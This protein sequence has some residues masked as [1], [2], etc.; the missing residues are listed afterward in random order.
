MS[1][2]FEV[3][4]NSATYG[5]DYSM[6]STDVVLAPGETSKRVPV[7]IIDDQMPELEESF[8]VS[9]LQQITGGATLGAVRECT[10]V[11]LPSDDPHGAF[12]EQRLHQ[13]RLS[14]GGFV[15]ATLVDKVQ[16]IS[17]IDI[18][19]DSYNPLSLIIVMLFTSLVN[20]KYKYLSH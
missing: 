9:L 11:I 16:A 2:R 20:E 8:T 14:V 18:W 6:T 3:V 19:S 10:V 1:V 5:L 12:G 15:G 4:S 17:I 13:G 7:E